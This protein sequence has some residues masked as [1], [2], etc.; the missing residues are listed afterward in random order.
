MGSLR[1]ALSQLGMGE[2]TETFRGEGFE[3][4]EHMQETPLDSAEMKEIGLNLKQ[5]K[6]LQQALKSHWVHLPAQAPPPQAPGTQAPGAPAGRA[7]PPPSPATSSAPATES[8]PAIALCPPQLPATAGGGGCGES[9]GGAKGTKRD[10]AAA[11]AAVGGMNH[12]GG[13]AAA[14]WSTKGDGG[15][16][17]PAAATRGTKRGQPPGTKRLNPMV[18]KRPQ[19]AAAAERRVD[20]EELTVD[21]QELQPPRRYLVA[22]EWSR[23][24]DGIVKRKARLAKPHGLG[25]EKAIVFDKEDKK[26]QDLRPQV[27]DALLGQALVADKVCLLT[28]AAGLPVQCQCSDHGPTYVFTPA[29]PHTSGLIFRSGA[30]GTGCNL[31]NGRREPGGGRA[32][33]RA[34]R[35]ARPRVQSRGEARPAAAHSAWGVHGGGRSRGRDCGSR[36]AEPSHV[37]ILRHDRRVGGRAPARRQR[38][39]LV[40]APPAALF[41]PHSRWACHLAS[42]TRVKV[43]LRIVSVDDVHCC[44]PLAHHSWPTIRPSALHRSAADGSLCLPLSLDRPAAT[45]SR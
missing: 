21:W 32:V 12:G 3:T 31:P 36:R 14:A 17:A 7:P 34:R 39:D 16:A 9:H 19:P 27:E 18:G 29:A 25:G 24:A 42:H 43:H 30:G 26:F 28:S 33:G 5:R 6:T 15:T 2:L 11:A 37:L 40:H 23:A 20:W 44:K 41:S 10:G 35:L 45:S 38:L 22:A 8:S 1:E 4:W 13:S